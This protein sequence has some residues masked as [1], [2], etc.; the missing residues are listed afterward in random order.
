M[1]DAVEEWVL[2]VDES[3]DF[4]SD[5]CSCVIGLALRERESAE[6]ARQLRACVELCFPLVPWPPHATELNVPITRA[7]ACLLADG[8][9]SAVRDTCAPALAALEG[10]RGQ[11]EVDRL[12]AATE[13][14]RMPD[15]VDLQSADG[16]L[17]RRA[18][19][20]HQALLELRDRQRRHVRAL[21][22]QLVQLYGPDDVFV[23]GA[24]QKGDGASRA[25]AYSRCLGAL[26][27]RLLALL[28]EEGRERVVR[29]RVATR[30]VLDPRLRASVP[31]NARHIVEAVEAAKPFAARLTGADSSVRLVPLEHV[32][33]Y[34]RRVHAGVVLADFLSNRLRSVLRR[35]TSWARTEEGVRERVGVAAQARARSWEAEVLPA[36]AHEGPARA[37]LERA[38]GLD[39]SERPHL[40]F[41]R[42]RWAGEQARLWADAANAGAEVGA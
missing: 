7:A 38:L 42:P 37:W 13:A 5:P 35:N 19:A 26:L 1:A 6:L 32:T 21:F 17:R 24:A 12:F 41:M 11:V 14:R 15:Y 39:P 22:A 29:F 8:G 20:A 3:G 16:W 33:K 4:E 9:D 30:G 2:Y 10:G 31:L 34:D 36:L 28:Q 23:V 25:D 27:E 40:G 18:P